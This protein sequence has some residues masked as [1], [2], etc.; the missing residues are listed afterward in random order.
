MKI[1]LLDKA[2]REGNT[3]SKGGLTLPLTQIFKGRFNGVR[4]GATRPLPDGHRTRPPRPDISL[5]SEQPRSTLNVD[6]NKKGWWSDLV[7]AP[8]VALLAIRFAMLYSLHIA[9]CIAFMC[10]AASNL[11]GR[12][13]RNQKLVVIVPMPSS[14]ISAMI[15]LISK[16]SF[17]KVPK[18][19]DNDCIRKCVI[20]TTKDTAATAIV[21]DSQQNVP[22]TSNGH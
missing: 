8:P 20:K 11:F 19:I 14:Q 10:S 12:S 2:P 13:R 16:V 21:P 1:G 22:K 17:A 4:C 15:S 5:Q 3:Q 9:L 6:L 7:G 18:H